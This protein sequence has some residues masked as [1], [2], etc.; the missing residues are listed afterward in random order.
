MDPNA[1][2]REQRDLIDSTDPDDVDRLGELRQALREW[3]DRGGFPPA[4]DRDP[5]VSWAFKRWRTDREWTDNPEIDQ[6]PRYTP[7]KVV[8]V[9]GRG[10]VLATVTGVRAYPPGTHPEGCPLI[11]G[12]TAVELRTEYGSRWYGCGSAYI[13]AEL[14]M[15]IIGTHRRDEVRMGWERVPADRL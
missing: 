2:L 11:E 12:C 8:V 13:N 1:N 3:L 10:G 5:A 4:W 15:V 14:R 7:N 6:T 9:A